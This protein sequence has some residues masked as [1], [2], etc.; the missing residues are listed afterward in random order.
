M[1]DDKLK[2]LVKNSS[3]SL[4]TL[5]EIISLSEENEKKYAE[6]RKQLYNVLNEL[7]QDNPSEER[8]IQACSTLKDIVNEYN[9]AGDNLKIKEAARKFAGVGKIAPKDYKEFFDALLEDDKED[10]ISYLVQVMSFSPDDLLRQAWDF[11]KEK[12]YGEAFNLASAAKEGGALLAYYLL[13]LLYQNGEGVVQNAQTAHSLFLEGAQKGEFSCQYQVYLHLVAGIGVERNLEAAYKWLVAAAQN[14]HPLAMLEYGKFLCEESVAQYDKAYEFIKKAAEAGVEEAKVWVGYCYEMGYGVPK[15]VQQAKNIYRQEMYKGNDYANEFYQKLVAA[16]NRTAQQQQWQK[17]QEKTAKSQSQDS[18]LR[19]KKSDGNKNGGCGWIILLVILAG[20]IWA[21]YQFWYKDY[22]I[23]K[24]APRT[25]V[26]A[27][28][29]FIRSSAVADVEYN[30]IGTVPYGSELVTYSKENGWAY[31]KADGKK[32]YVSADYLL[33]AGDFLL[34]NGVWGNA[35]AKEAIA[36]AKC[37]LAVLDFLKSNKME[38]GSSAWQVFTK[39]KEMKPNSVLFPRLADGYDHFTEFAFILKN[40]QTKL[41]KLVLY[42][43][44]E[45]ETPVFRHAENAPEQGDI[46]A[47]TYNKWTKRYNVTYTTGGAYVAQPKATTPV[48]VQQPESLTVTSVAF[49]NTDFDRKVLTAYGQQLRTDM[50]YL[51]SKVFYRKESG[52]TLQAKWQVKLFRPDGTL[53]QGSTSPAGCTF[54]Q[55][56]TLNGTSGTVELL[57]WGSRNGDAY[58]AGNYRYEIWHNGNRLSSSVVKVKDMVDASEG[59][60]SITTVYFADGTFERTI[61]TGYGQQLYSDTQYLQS[62]VHYKKNSGATEQF[63]LKIKIVKP[64]GDVMNGNTPPEGYT[65]EHNATFSGKSGVVELPGWGN[66]NGNAYPAGN[67][68]YEIWL[69]GRKLLSATMITIKDKR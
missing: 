54:E 9:D 41:R 18:Q 51:Q 65:F 36:T 14:G 30:R 62:K 34:L 32:G 47:I 4:Y 66:K 37:R 38:T 67:Y 63:L 40:N 15:N 13:G 55:E 6:I 25:Y 44:E 28:S 69:E 48:A 5:K 60:L 53:V 43:F 45:D 17:T 46:K 31:V 29:L 52:A 59:P 2:V 16:E 27:N 42:A 20:F 68:R 33:D 23:D 3:K 49:A 12:R 7:A 64:S 26:F 57:G 61:R 10:V 11:H 8:L 21:G 56:V 39:Q 50:Q 35:E 22:K 19:K 58:V 1:T 24:E